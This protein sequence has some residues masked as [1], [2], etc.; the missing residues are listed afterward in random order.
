MNKIRYKL[1][2]IQHNSYWIASV[3]CTDTHIQKKGQNPGNQNKLIS[4]H[5]CHIT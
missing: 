2:H 1:K 5:I 3:E 4:I